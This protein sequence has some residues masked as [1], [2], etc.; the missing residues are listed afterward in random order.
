VET[1]HYSTLML[2]SHYY[3]EEVKQGT[4]FARRMHDVYHVHPADI[5]I[6]DLH[7]M[8]IEYMSLILYKIEDDVIE[9]VVS[10]GVLLI[11]GTV[12]PISHNAT[13][14]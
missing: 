10:A 4:C 1:D 9:R 11:A 6:V 3:T 2:R 12:V 13:V 8:D 5:C 7:A 14:Q